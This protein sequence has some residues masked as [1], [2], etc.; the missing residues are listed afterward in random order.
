M[1]AVAFF[2]SLQESTKP[3]FKNIATSLDG[4]L[5]NDNVILNIANSHYVTLSHCLD[6]GLRCLAPFMPYMTEEL[7]PRVPYIGDERTPDATRSI[8]DVN[9]PV[10]EH[11]SYFILLFYTLLYAFFLPS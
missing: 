3:A 9:F 1:I 5:K 8:N 6:I 10:T 4:H 2:L 11:V 7:Y